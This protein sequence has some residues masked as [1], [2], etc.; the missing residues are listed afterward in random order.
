MSELDRDR[1]VTTLRGLIVD[2]RLTP[3][4][5]L[6]ERT[7]A[8][9]LGLSRVPVREAL[10]ILVAEGFAAERPTGGVVVRQHA[11]PGSAAQFGSA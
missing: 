11:D 9:E 10:Q 5:R 1:A 7:L 6:V 2:G 4:Q 3:G 8:S